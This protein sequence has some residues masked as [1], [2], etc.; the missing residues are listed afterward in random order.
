MPLNIKLR[1]R[2]SSYPIKWIFGFLSC[3]IPW[4]TRKK[5]GLVV[6]TSFHGEGYR[7][8]TKVIFEALQSD[9]YTHIGLT[10]IWLSTN[11]SI[12]Q[13]LNSRYGADV[14][15]NMYSFKALIKLAQAEYILL[16][17]G[18]T[19]YPFLCLP[20][21]AVIVQTYHG[22]P[23]KR[24]ERFRLDGQEPLSR[25]EDRYYSRVYDPIDIFLSSSDFVSDIFHKRFGIA[26]EKFH[27]TGYPAYDR[28]NHLEIDHEFV[29]KLHSEADSDTKIV[30]YAPTFRSKNPT[31]LFPFDDV[32]VDRIHHFLTKNNLVIAIRVHPNEKLNIAPYLGWSDRIID[33]GDKIIED[34]TDLIVNSCCIITDYSSVYLEGLQRDIPCIFIPY[35]LNEYERGLPFDYNAMAPGPKVSDSDQ[36]LDALD[37]C[38]E[39]GLKSYS[40]QRNIVRDLVFN[41][42]DAGATGRVLELIRNHVSSN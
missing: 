35:D 38:I 24:G 28:L 8:N 37:Q 32:D 22:L 31:R 1:H 29:F 34:V 9:T 25:L 2:L 3:L 15:A 39:N 42:M 10:G 26:R 27:I 14:A 23:T 18:I 12:V 13:D 5:S 36:F 20:S 19:D 4:V 17:H 16:T 11:P 30:L 6:L 33:A 21:R 40:A 7:G 41:H